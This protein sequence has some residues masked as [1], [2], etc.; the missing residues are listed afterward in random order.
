MK[1]FGLEGVALVGYSMGSILVL[2]LAGEW[3]SQ[4]PLCAVAAICPAIDL[5]ADSNETGCEP[6]A[7]A[8]AASLAGYPAVGKPGCGPG[9]E[10][11]SSN[12]N[13]RLEWNDERRCAEGLLARSSR[14]S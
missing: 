5:A 13:L 9:N 10:G 14:R 7:T 3:A 11:P 2:N 12:F 4:P 8:G 6:G 1:Q